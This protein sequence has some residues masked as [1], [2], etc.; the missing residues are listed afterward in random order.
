[1]VASPSEAESVDYFC[2]Q[3]VRAVAKSE[4]SVSKAFLANL[5][6]SILESLFV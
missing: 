5:A 3:E 4:D 1:M 2:V 6:A